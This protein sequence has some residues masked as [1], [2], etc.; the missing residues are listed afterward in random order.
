MGDY[1]TNLLPAEQFRLVSKDWVQKDGAARML[2]ENKTAVL[3]QRMNALGEMPTSKAERL[4]KASDE[5][6]LYLESMVGAR[7][8]ANLA[9]VKMKYVEMMY[10]EHQSQNASR[11]AEIRL[12]S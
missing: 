11:R 3:S 1:S 5:W 4:V 10:F 12:T 6:A 9:K 7:T 2:E 8:A